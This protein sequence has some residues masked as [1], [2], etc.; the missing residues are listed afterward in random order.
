[1]DGPAFVSTPVSTGESFETSAPVISIDSDGA[2]RATIVVDSYSYAPNHF[3][4]EVGTP[5]ELILESVTI[6]TP[7][8]LC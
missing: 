8:N 6:V 4:V 3:Q 7:H 1:M 5:V 2:Q